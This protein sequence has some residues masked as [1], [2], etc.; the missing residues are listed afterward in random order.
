MTAIV[1]PIHPNLLFNNILEGR[2]QNNRK[3]DRVPHMNHS[4]SC[5]FLLQIISS[6]AQHGN[7][8]PGLTRERHE[9]HSSAKFGVVHAPKN[10]RQGTH[11]EN[12]R[13]PCSKWPSNMKP[14]R[15]GEVIERN[16]TI[17]RTFLSF[18][19]DLISNFIILYYERKLMPAIT[20]LF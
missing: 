3:A 20:I 2:H 9:R 10:D 6:K 19:N 8:I 4:A 17:L 12:S 18:N 14:A 1:T 5:A 16:T 13:Q 7:M 11:T 15:Q